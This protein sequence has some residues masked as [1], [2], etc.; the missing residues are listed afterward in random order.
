MPFS[1]QGAPATFQRLMDQVLRGLDHF[2]ATYLDNVVVVSESWEEHIKHLREVMQQLKYAGLTV[3]QKKVSI[4]N[5]PLCLF[6]SCAWK[7]RSISRA[8]QDS[9]SQ[10]ISSTKN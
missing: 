6:R 9:S 5:G 2:T 1:L 7:R 10:I 3:Q 8:K 4:W